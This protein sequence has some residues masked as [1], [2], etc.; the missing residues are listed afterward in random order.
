MGG[1]G[2]AERVAV[3][4]PAA[5]GGINTG[6]A[7]AK[8]RDEAEFGQGVRLRRG[9]QGIHQLKEGVGGMGKAA[10]ESL[11]KRA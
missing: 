3:E 5:Q 4:C 2:G 11:A 1:E 7:A 8:R 6:P 9:D 10:I